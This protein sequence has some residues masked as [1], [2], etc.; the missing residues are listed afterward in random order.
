MIKLRKLSISYER[1][2]QVLL[3][4]FCLFLAF[5]IWSIHKLSGDYSIYLNYRVCVSTDYQGKSS[6]AYSENLLILK[7]RANG[8]YILK[9]RYLRGEE[10]LY[11]QVE[12][13]FFKKMP[14]TDAGYF[15]LSSNIR[16]KLSE[17]FGK[18]IEIERLAVDTLFFNFSRH[19]N[20]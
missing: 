2:R 12:K 19:I 10:T 15:L 7:G 3:F 6:A 1:G 4:L 17:N 9:Q 5:I 14:D 13:S 16:D 20:K 11:L 18:N 8:F